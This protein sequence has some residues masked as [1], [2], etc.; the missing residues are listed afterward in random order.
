MKKSFLFFISITAAVIILLSFINGC[1]KQGYPDI[2]YKSKIPASAVKM[3]PEMDKHPPILH[4]EEYEAPVPLAD[5]NTAGAEDSPF[6]PDSGDELY[7]F[8]TPDV[9]VPVEKQVIDEVT[10][11]YVSKKVNGA[12]QSPVRVHLQDPGKLSL[13]GCEFVQGNTIWFCAAREGHTGLHWVKASRKKTSDGGWGAWA[14]WEVSDF[15]AEY[16]VGELHIHGDELYFH[17]A[18]EGGKGGNDIWMSNRVGGS[19]LPPV[20]LANVNSAAD[21]GYPYITPDGQELWFT[22][23]YEGTPAVFRSKRDTDNTW[24]EPELIVSQFA[25][26]PTLDLEDNLYFVHHYFDEGNMIEADIYVAYRKK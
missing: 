2:D 1:A 20:V 24:L 9:K 26:E 14:D 13:D 8:F 10:G 5:V 23:Q 12:W 25:G 15:P 17:S 11:I 4:S 19:W 21:D 7:L 6:I 3:T 22:R 18:H 16:Q